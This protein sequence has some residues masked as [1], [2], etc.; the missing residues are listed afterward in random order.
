MRLPVHSVRPLPGDLPSPE[1]QG[2]VQPGMP[3]G[4]GPSG[5]G[6]FPCLVVGS[7]RRPCPWGPGYPVAPG[8]RRPVTA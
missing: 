1:T 2:F 8:R 3:A 6:P 5:D 4:A 7:R